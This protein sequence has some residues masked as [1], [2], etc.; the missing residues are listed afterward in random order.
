[1]GLPKSFC[2]MHLSILNCANNSISSNHLFHCFK[3]SYGMASSQSMLLLQ[4][5][6]CICFVVKWIGAIYPRDHTLS[7]LSTTCWL[8][9]ASTHQ[10]SPKALSIGRLSLSRF[11]SFKSLDHW[12]SAIDCNTA[13]LWSIFQKLNHL[14]YRGHRALNCLHG[15]LFW[16]RGHQAVAIELELEAVSWWG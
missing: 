2:F 15:L 11:S 1:M 7:W 3:I 16:A 5:S 14:I 8:E 13:I 10:S 9:T 6:Y 4:S 12:S